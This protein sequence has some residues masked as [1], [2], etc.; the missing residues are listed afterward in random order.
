MRRKTKLSFSLHDDPFFAWL[1]EEVRARIENLTY[2]REYEPKQIVFFPDD[3]CDQVYWVRAGRVK[4]TRVAADGKELTLRHA[5]AGEMLGEDCLTQATRRG[6]FAE[7]MSVSVLCIMRATDFRCLMQ[8]ESEFAVLVSQRLAERVA[9]QEQ[10]LSETVFKSVRARTASGLLRLYRHVPEPERET[11]HVTHQE[12]ASLIGA[13]RETTTTV[14]H[15]L[16]KDGLIAI[17]NRRVHILDAA[18]LELI[19]RSS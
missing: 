11:L 2:F 13:T 12:L 19:A 16:R 9:E 1:G 4:V 3:A 15:A 18:G 10:V 6:V 8:E 7:A 14:L 5:F 17:A